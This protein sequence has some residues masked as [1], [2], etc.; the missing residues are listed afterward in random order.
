M[1]GLWDVI[2]AGSGALWH[3]LLALQASGWLGVLFAALWRACLPVCLSVCLSVFQAACIPAC[4]C[5]PDICRT[6]LQRTAWT[7]IL[8][9]A[10]KALAAAATAGADDSCERMGS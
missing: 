4:T 9:A 10:A 6:Y 2:V 3:G 1:F 5:V 8:T 7:W